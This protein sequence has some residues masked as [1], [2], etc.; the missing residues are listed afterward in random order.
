MVRKFL[1]VC[2]IV[3][4]L[5]YV[6]AEITA[7]MRWEAYRY[8]SQMVSEL[9]AIGAPTRP[10]LV[11]CFTVHNTLA[12]AFGMGVWASGGRKLTLRI[13]GI[14]LVAYGLV[15]EAAL[16]FGPMHLRGSETTTTDTMHIVFTTVIVLLTLFFIGLG[17]IAQ[18]RAFR[19]YSMLTIVVLL[20]FGALAGLQ[21][22]RMTTGLPTPGFGLIER[23]NIYASMLWMLV[24]A[25][26]L[27][28][29]S[30]YAA[31]R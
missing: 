31:Q 7:S 26:A 21:G 22:P 25:V 14:L 8:A 19:I 28:R 17:A 12:A 18:G 29:R 15:G 24:F 2:G 9:M 10:F 16:L 27:L 1:L 23:V 13:A 4:P 11:V 20:V 5:V 30:G 6:G 3:S